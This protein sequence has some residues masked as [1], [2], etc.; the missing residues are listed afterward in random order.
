MFYI[1]KY[2]FVLKHL[3]MWLLL[4]IVNS[5]QFKS[6]LYWP[7][8]N[9]L[10][11]SPLLIR[12]KWNVANDAFIYIANLKCNVNLKKQDSVLVLRKPG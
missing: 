1:Q 6:C 7:S 10:I 5:K 11:S 9:Y 4:A 2:L 12:G 3:A 8:F